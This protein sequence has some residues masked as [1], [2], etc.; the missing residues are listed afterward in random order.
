MWRNDRKCKHKFLFH[1]KN[2]ARKGLNLSGYCIFL[3]SIK[4]NVGPPKVSILVDR[5]STDVRSTISKTALTPVRW[6][7]SYVFL[8]LTHQNNP[9]WYYNS[10]IPLVIVR[11]P[12]KK[13][14][15]STLATHDFQILNQGMSVEGVWYC[16]CPPSQ[17]VKFPL[18]LGMSLIYLF[19]ALGWYISSSFQIKYMLSRAARKLVGWQI[20]YIYMCVYMHIHSHI[21]YLT[22]QAYWFW[23]F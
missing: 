17:I 1:L 11:P 2:F 14:N 4:I 22:R 3:W 5:M 16:E 6:Q 9:I 18:M 20:S 19:C 8:A 13:L 12:M 21:P 15:D 10:Y 7:W 23:W